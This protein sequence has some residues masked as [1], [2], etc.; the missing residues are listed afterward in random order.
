MSTMTQ[1]HEAITAT[2][3]RI[4]AIET[5]QGVTPDALAAI[6][7]ELVALATREDLFPGEEFHAPEKGALYRL[8][9]D[10]DHRF[11]LYAVTCVKS[12]SSP[13]HN[14]T[15]WAAI[16]GVRGAERNTIYERTDNRDTP[17]VGR[18]RQVGEHTVVSGTAVAYMPDD[19]HAIE[20][21]GDGPW[22]QLHLYGRSLE[23]LP[24]RIKFEGPEGGAYAVYPANPTIGTLEL[25]AE[26]VKGFIAD[27]EELALLDVREEA[28]F[29]EGHL[30]LASNLPTSRLEVE[31]PLLVPRRTTRVIVIDA[32]GEGLAQHAARRL[33]DLGWKNIAV[34]HGGVAGWR[35]AGYVVFS[36]FNV[37]SKAFGEVV[38]H[39]RDTPHIEAA[40]LKQRLDAGEEIVILDSRPFDEFQVMSIPGGLDAPGVE[41]VGRAHAVLRSPD[42]PVV[43]NCAGRTRS[44]IGAQ[45]LI[46]AGLPNPVAALKDGTMGWHL[47]GFDLAHGRTEQAP[48]PDPAALAEAQRAAQAM[49]ERFGVR[50]IDH[51]MLAAFRAEAT[52]RSLFCFDVRTPEEYAAGHLPG[53]HHAAGGQLVQATDTYVGT[54][55][56]RIVLADDDGVRAKLTASWLLQA[57]WDDVFVLENAHAGQTL[58]TAPE[59]HVLPVP[60]VKLVSPAALQADRGEAVVFDLSLSR[61]YRAGHVPGAIWISRPRLAEAGR[62]VPASRSVVLVSPDGVLA[63]YAAAELDRPGVAVLDG[64][65]LA[66]RAAGHPEETQAQFAH[67]PADAWLR[68]DDGTNTPEGRMRG[69]LAW[70]VAL[71]AL[72]EQDG[73]CRFRVG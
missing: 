60:E 35:D 34:L 31:A 61:T 28:A 46:N 24:G 9:E 41:L 40:A 38:E 59:P 73:D 23:H 32:A 29:S 71:P 48:R 10:A 51:A 4:T 19:F 68:P 65:T 52:Q 6:K 33:F 62:A 2:I 17:G 64:G 15:T 30:L 72:V 56:S 58:Q 20:M 13:V 22:V 55:R 21:V 44:I 37:P 7:T 5:S 42:T 12:R 49:A 1:R 26:T 39:T 50:S 27:G 16:A 8:A 63:R 53:F 3:G 36:G 57:G 66:W 14:H 70:E 11:A 54:L 25:P 67:E 69:Y 18:L 45:L 43:V 47:A